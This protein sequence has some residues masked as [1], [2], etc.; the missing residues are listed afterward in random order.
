MEAAEGEDRQQP[1]LVGPAARGPWTWGAAVSDAEPP[2]PPPL[3]A[4]SLHSSGGA[5]RKPSTSR[6][7]VQALV[8]AA[9]KCEL[10]GKGCLEASF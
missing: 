8:S 10:Q 7:C 6:G 9:E 3:R 1:N 4:Q 2:P 5:V